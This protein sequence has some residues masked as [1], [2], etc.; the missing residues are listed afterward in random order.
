MGLINDQHTVLAQQEVLLEL[1]EQDA[2]CHE[3]DS[4]GG[5]HVAIIPHLQT[6][7]SDQDTGSLDGCAA[8]ALKSQSSTQHSAQDTCSQ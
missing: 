6:R 5:A 3:F 8:I 2:V 4:C 7:G 1:P